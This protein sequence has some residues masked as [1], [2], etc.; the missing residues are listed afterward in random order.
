MDEMVVRVLYG[1]ETGTAQD[2]A[3]QI[4][5]SAKRFS[6]CSSLAREPSPL[7]KFLA[8]KLYSHIFKSL[9]RHDSLV[10]MSVIFNLYNYIASL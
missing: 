6:C 5:K 1:S 3:E 7:G 2:V 8:H 9:N 10:L 4:W